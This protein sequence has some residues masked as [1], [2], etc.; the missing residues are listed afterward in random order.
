MPDTTNS[1]SR[2]SAAL[3]FP[4]RRRS[5]TTMGRAL[6]SCAG[7]LGLSSSRM[8]STE[9]RKRHERSRKA[10]RSTGP[11]SAAHR[12]SGAHAHQVAVHQAPDPAD[13]GPR[14][15][16]AG[17]D[18]GQRRNHPRGNRHRVPRRS[19]EPAP[20]ARGGRRR[21]RPTGS[22]SSP[23]GMVAVANGAPGVR[24]V[25]AEPGAQRHHRRRQRRF[26]AGVRTAVRA[27]SRRRSPLRHHRGFP[28]LRETRLSDADPPPF[29]RDGVRARGP[30]RQ[31]A[32]PGH[33]L[34][35]HPLFR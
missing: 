26:R 33:G 10:N 31:Q 16:G 15:R 17:D 21:G 8:P 27:R 6:S 23:H 22:Y 2:T 20:V 29:G 25:C 7:G 11:R 19:G 18:R 32:P 35:P 30:G 3:N 28:Q 5:R 34:Q 12:A 24:A 4:I 13:R 1:G 9:G 14:A